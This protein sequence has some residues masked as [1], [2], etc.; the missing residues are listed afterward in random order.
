MKVTDEESD[1]SAEESKHSH[2][3][4]LADKLQLEEDQQEATQHQPRHS[5]RHSERPPILRATGARPCTKPATGAR[6]WTKWKL[7]KFWQRGACDKGENCCY[8]HGEEEIN[9]LCRFTE[10]QKTQMCDF[11]KKK[12]P[13]PNREFCQ[14]A[15]GYREIGDPKPPKKNA[16]KN[17]QVVQD[18]TGARN[19]WEPPHTGIAKEVEATTKWAKM[20]GTSGPFK[21]GTSGPPGRKRARSDSKLSRKESRRGGGGVNPLPQR[22]QEDSARRHRSHRDDSRE[23][24]KVRHIRGGVNLLPG[25]PR[26][27][28]DSATEERRHRRH[29]D[30]DAREKVLRI[31]IQTCSLFPLCS[32]LSAK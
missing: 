31:I 12:K 13:C 6:P 19:K 16:K 30:D 18:E 22:E 9:Q 32:N 20:E 1:G 26:E 21:E 8:A 27:P 15:H 24:Q 17:W 29:R 11:Y 2:N 28:E 14:L 25:P 10:W 3:P 4:A 5:T 23:S 7:C